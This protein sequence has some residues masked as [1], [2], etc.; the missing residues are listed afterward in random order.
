MCFT[1]LIK[2]HVVRSK[3]KRLLLDAHFY[4]ANAITENHERSNAEGKSLRFGKRA[5]RVTCAMRECANCSSAF[6][7]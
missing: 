1:E 2:L 7:S 5:Y 4:A 6:F 3:T